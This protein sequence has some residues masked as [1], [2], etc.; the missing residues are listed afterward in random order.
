MLDKQNQHKLNQENQIIHFSHLVFYQLLLGTGQTHSKAKQ[1]QCFQV[2]IWSGYHAVLVYTG[3]RYW[4]NGRW[5]STWSMLLIIPKKTERPEESA[6]RMK[7]NMTTQSTDAASS[8]PCLAREERGYGHPVIVHAWTDFELHIHIYIY[9][10][11]VLQPRTTTPR[12]M[13]VPGTV[14]YHLI[15]TN[16]IVP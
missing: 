13:P 5:F 14:L 12:S 11:Y 8:Q 1:Q 3:T 2:W 9:I 15:T 16:K 4:M 6:W 10:S 7:Q